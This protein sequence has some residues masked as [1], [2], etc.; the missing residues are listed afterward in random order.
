MNRTIRTSLVGLSALSLLT[1]SGCVSDSFTIDGKH[2][3]PSAIKSVSD[4]AIAH[5]RAKLAKNSIGKNAGAQSPRDIDAKYGLN[6]K[7]TKHAPTPSQM[8]LCDIHFHKSAEHKGGQFTKYAGNGD[9][10][11]FGTGY[12]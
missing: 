1:F 7:K 6:T 11:G 3:E 9:G 10:E 8:N 12:M 2:H 4:S 5:Q